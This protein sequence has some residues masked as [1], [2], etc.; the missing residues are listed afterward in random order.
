[1]MGDRFFEPYLIGFIGKM[2][3]T[4]YFWVSIIAMFLFLGL[5]VI[6][7]YSK[8][9]PDPAI[10]NRIIGIE[11]ELATNRSV[12]EFTQIGLYQRLEDNERAREERSIARACAGRKRRKMNMTSEKS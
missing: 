12:F 11:E 2:Q 7:A 9:P 3:V 10:L 5:R 1:M 6:I 4:T 8:P